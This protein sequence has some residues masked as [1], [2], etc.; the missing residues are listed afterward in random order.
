M[1]VLPATAAREILAELEVGTFQITEVPGTRQTGP[2]AVEHGFGSHS[3]L[4]VDGIENPLGFGNVFGP[5]WIIDEI[6]RHAAAVENSYP[7]GAF[8]LQ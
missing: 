6:G 8:R 3:V 7:A 1:A 5:S 2:G 4:L